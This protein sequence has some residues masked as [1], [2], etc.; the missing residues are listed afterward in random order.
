MLL[1]LCGHLSIGPRGVLAQ[2]NEAINSA[3]WPEAGK[4]LSDAASEA[5]IRKGFLK[6]LVSEP[7]A[8]PSLRL[9]DKD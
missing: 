6:R 2:S 1:R 3:I 4:K 7:V 9:K 5:P 8:R